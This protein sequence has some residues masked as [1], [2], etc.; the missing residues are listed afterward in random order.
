MIKVPLTIQNPSHG[1]DIRL[2]PDQL[3]RVFLAGNQFYLGGH[4][5]RMVL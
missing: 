4:Y 5:V 3:F 2:T 1:C